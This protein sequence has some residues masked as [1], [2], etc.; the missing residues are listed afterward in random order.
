MKD[1]QILELSFCKTNDWKGLKNLFLVD[2]LPHLY[3]S[4]RKQKEQQL[5]KS[6]HTNLDQ[7]RFYPISK[8]YQR[9]FAA[10]YNN[11][12][13]A[14]S[15]N[16]TQLLGPTYSDLKTPVNQQNKTVFFIRFLANAV[17]CISEKQEEL[18]EKG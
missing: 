13:Y 10:A 12:A 3:R 9:F 2:T 14:L 5:T 1:R 6:P 7:L 15:L 18:C 17:K 11:K 8:V 16:L 4:S